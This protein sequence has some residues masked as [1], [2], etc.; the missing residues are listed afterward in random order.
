M[1]LKFT[2]LT[3]V[4]VGAFIGLAI[5]GSVR[6]L[7]P[8]L[9]E[10]A[11][12]KQATRFDE[13]PH[14][15][16][17][18]TLASVHDDMQPFSLGLSGG[19]LFIGYIGSDRVDEYSSQ[20]QLLRSVHLLENEKASITGI[21]VHHDRLYAVNN[22]IGEILVSDYPSGKL[23]TT[24]GFFPDN[25]TRMKVFG[26]ALQNDILYAT[27]S[28]TNRILA[29][30]ANEIPS[31]RDEGELLT[32]FPDSGAHEYQLSFP[33]F[34]VVTPD[35]RLL[36][37]DIGH[38]EVK[39]FTCS[40]RPAHK[41]DRSDSA[42]MSIPMGIAFDNLPSPELLAFRDSIFNPSGLFHQGRIHIVDA[43][44]SR[45][46]VFSSTGKYVFSYGKELHKPAG[47]AIDTSRRYIFIADAGPS[48]IQMYTY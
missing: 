29:I 46:K 11:E 24:Y 34:P 9:V 45:V 18:M 5:Y 17:E 33:S 48:V 1:K 37:S 4:A 2:P 43:G 10:V 32:T 3:A 19:N 44:S 26:I 8:S 30:S 14:Y 12:S 35:G 42:Q 16:G 38:H 25:S 7:N 39:A 47:I 13:A 28:R 20:L 31:I 6:F 21:I 27:D 36:V 40:G 22:R 41:L 15:V 23:I